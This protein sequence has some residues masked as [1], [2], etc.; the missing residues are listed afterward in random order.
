MTAETPE[1]TVMAASLKIVWTLEITERTPA[2]TA[3]KAAPTLNIIDRKAVA[4]LPASDGAQSPSMAHSA[5]ALMR[6]PLC[7]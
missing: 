1:R 4:M 7:I 3:P 5:T 6:G 2:T